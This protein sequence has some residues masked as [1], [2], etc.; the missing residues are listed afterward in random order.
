RNG[1]NGGTSHVGICGIC[2]FQEVVVIRVEDG[3]RGLAYVYKIEDVWR[4]QF[5]SI[6][7]MIFKKGNGMFFDLFVNSI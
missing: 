1:C 3:I 2:F 4:R 7:L 5:S 6:C